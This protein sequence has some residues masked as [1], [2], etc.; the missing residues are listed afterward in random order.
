MQRR[1]RLLQKLLLQQQ[2]LSHPPCGSQQLA[3]A[4]GLCA[5]TSFPGAPA[6]SEPSAYLH[7]QGSLQLQQQQQQQQRAFGPGS[8]DSSIGIDAQLPAPPSIVLAPPAW[9]T[10][11]HVNDVHDE[12]ET[13]QARSEMQPCT[14][15]G[16][17][18][19]SGHAQDCKPPGSHNNSSSSSR[20]HSSSSNS[21]RSSS[22]SSLFSSHNTSSKSICLINSNSSCT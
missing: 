21:S 13:C 10:G 22:C 3:C 17:C 12:G 5:H 15:Q 4:S 1:V 16:C 20:V 9:S 8:G 6:E 11:K 14:Q 7:T 18:P 2:L 19:A